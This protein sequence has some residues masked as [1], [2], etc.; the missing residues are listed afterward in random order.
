[1][2]S[3]TCPYVST[4]TIPKRIEK[5]DI[6]K[7]VDEFI[8]IWLKEGTLNSD[9]EFELRQLINHIIVFENEQYFSDDG[10]RAMSWQLNQELD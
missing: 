9:V 3:S 7:N 2:S 1:M 6:E 8:I 4:S 5:Y 10:P